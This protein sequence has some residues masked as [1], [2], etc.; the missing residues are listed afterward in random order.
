MYV[1]VRQIGYLLLSGFYQ[2]VRWTLNRYLS[3]V[4]KGQADGLLIITLMLA[5]SP[6]DTEWIFTWCR[7]RS[8]GWAI[9]YYID[10]VYGL[11]RH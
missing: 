7:R 9:E 1:A 10:D 8:G 6:M 3:C 5:M 2:W 4:D 11:G